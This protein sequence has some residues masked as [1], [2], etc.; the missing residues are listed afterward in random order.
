M[1]S[2]EPTDHQTMSLGQ[3]HSSRP[4]FRFSPLYGNGQMREE[5]S[6]SGSDLW[7]SERGSEM[8]STRDEAAMR[9]L[10]APLQVPCVWTY[11]DRS[12]EKD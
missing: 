10:D 8:G 12:L 2:L 9:D 6:P 5:D 1:Q 3:F 11:R 4:P 7:G